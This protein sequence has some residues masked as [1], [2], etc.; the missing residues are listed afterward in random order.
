MLD[1]DRYVNNSIEVKIAGEIYDILEPTLAVNMEVN[2][3]E[4]DLTEEN[5]FEK[6]VDVAKL[7]LDHNR[8]GKIFSKKEI[9]AIPFEGITQLL[10]GI[11]TMRT[12]AENDPN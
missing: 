10:A 4:E 6:R 11:S 3:I 12:K 7:F 1:L 2:R 9:T 8:Q 5:L